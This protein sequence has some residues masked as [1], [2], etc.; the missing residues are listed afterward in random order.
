MRSDIGLI[1]LGVMG[2]NL[3]LNIEQKGY[4][5]SVYNF[6]IHG[7]ETKVIDFVFEHVDSN[8]RAGEDLLDFVVSLQTP[9]VILMMVPAGEV[10]ENVMDQLLAITT[11]GDVIIDGGNSMYKDTIR[12][13][14]IASQKGIHFIGMGVSGGSEGAL[15]GPAL[16]PS[17]SAELRPI[18]EKLFEPCAAFSTYGSCLRWSDGHGAG[19][20]IKM[21]HNGIEYA[22]MQI[23]AESYHLLKESGVT[24]AEILNIFEGWKNSDMDGFLLDVTIDI[25]SH[26]KDVKILDKIKDVAGHKGTTQ[27]MFGAGLDLGIAMPTIAAAYHE[28]IISSSKRHPIAKQLENN[29][30]TLCSETLLSA[31]IMARNVA[32]IE[33]LELI[34]KASQ[35]YN[36]NVDIINM[37]KGW[38]GGCIIRSKLLDN[39]IKLDSNVE[40]I[41]EN[42]F[43]QLDSAVESAKSCVAFGFENNCSLPCISASL[44]KTLSLRTEHLNSIALIQAQREYFGSHG[45]V[46]KGESK[47]SHIDWPK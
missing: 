1:G 34:N 35:V 47:I 23:I 38:T 18:I 24:D 41:K 32:M 8:F 22:D 26:N 5:V 42:I 27:W 3:A 36:W 16:M 39:Y 33:G 12:R 19:H 43:G 14:A 25:L 15:N 6:P 44:Q 11:K 9:R 30:S 17:G 31:A 40:T 10:V 20:F 46:L 37:I 28:R 4:S 29:A 2:S 7:E 13:A 21:V 45:V